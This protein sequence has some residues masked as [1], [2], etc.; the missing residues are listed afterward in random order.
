MNQT[1][2]QTHIITT[3]NSTSYINNQPTEIID[4]ILYL[5]LPENTTNTTTEEWWTSYIQLTTTCKSWNMI[6][7][8][9]PHIWKQLFIRLNS[10]NPWMCW[11]LVTGW[12]KILNT[13]NRSYKLTLTIEHNTPLSYIGLISNLFSL[14]NSLQ[15]LCIYAPI[16]ESELLSYSLDLVTTSNL[17]TLIWVTKD[18][19]IPPNN[20]LEFLNSKF[21][22]PILTT[23]YLLSNHLFLLPLRL[24][25]RLTNLH[26]N[27]PNNKTDEYIELLANCPT[28]ITLT[29]G[30]IEI[31][32]TIAENETGI[33]LS[34]LTTLTVYPSLTAVSILNHL[35]TPRL[36]TFCIK[37]P[38]DTRQTSLHSLEEFIHQ[39]NTTLKS[40]YVKGYK[41]EEIQHAIAN[42]F[43]NAIWKL[44]W[45]TKHYTNYSDIY[46]IWIEYNPQI[47][48]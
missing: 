29:I 39:N 6:A 17:K 30:V 2:Q 1:F 19:S 14:Q 32:E 33:E 18:N 34:F 11:K 31:S 7:T 27:S 15:E 26:I 16:Q 23:F 13:H 38:P 47:Y 44:Y 24:T 3:F 41:R 40:I 43:Q 22:A 28:L 21:T 37:H 48:L 45:K 20:A 4:N 9:N 5:L 25:S 35:T 42:R 12:H 10:K 46:N 36:K 8:K